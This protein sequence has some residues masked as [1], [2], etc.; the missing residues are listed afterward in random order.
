MPDYLTTR[1]AAE[2]LGIRSQTLLYHIQMGRIS[3]VLRGSGRTGTMFFRPSD[4]RKLGKTIE[5]LHQQQ[6]SR[7]LNRKAPR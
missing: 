3:P 1:E 2:T 6:N 5:K 7:W 4:V